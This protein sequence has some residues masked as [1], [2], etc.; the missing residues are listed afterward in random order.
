MFFFVLN[1]HSTRIAI[2]ANNQ[3]KESFPLACFHIKQPTT[4]GMVNQMVVQGH[5][6]YEKEGSKDE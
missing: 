1:D 4:S 5:N 6:N 2:S 3:I